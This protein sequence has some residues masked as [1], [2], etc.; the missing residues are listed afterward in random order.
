MDFWSL[1]LNDA[2]SVLIGELLRPKRKS[3]RPEAEGLDQ[4]NFPTATENR[5]VPVPFGTTQVKGPNCTWYGD[6]QAQALTKRVRTGMLS[7][8]TVFLGYRYLVGME[9]GLCISNGVTLKEV[10][11]G[12]TKVFAG[13]VTHGQTFNVYGSWKESDLQ[14]GVD[15]TCEFYSPTSRATATQSAYV[16]GFV[17][18]NPGYQH[19][20]RV[21]WRGPSAG[22]S[23]F[24]GLSPNMRSLSFVVKRLPDVVPLG[25]PA[26]ENTAYGDLNGAANLAYIAL[27]LA[28]NDEWGAGY[29]LPLIDVDSFRQAAPVIFAEGNGGSFL[30]DG[31]CSVESML[32]Q[33]LRQMNGI[34]VE[35][36]T[37]GLLRLRLIRKGQSVAITI[38]DSN[39]GRIESFTRAAGEDA[40]NEV[41]LPFKDRSADFKD[42][43]A[44][45]QDLGGIRQVGQVVSATVQY[46]LVDNRELASTLVVRDLQVG[47]TALA[48][49]ELKVNVPPGTVLLPGDL[50]DVTLSD[51]GVNNMLM[52][53]LKVSLPGGRKPELSLELVQD[54]FA[55]GTALYAASVPALGG[56][57]DPSERPGPASWYMLG[58]FAP[59][60]LTGDDSAEHSLFMAGPPTTGYKGVAGYRVGYWTNVDTA[61]QRTADTVQWDEDAGLVGFAVKGTT[62][63]AYSRT[64]SGSFSIGISAQ[65]A[66]IV[67]RYPGRDIYVMVQGIGTVAEFMRARVALTSPSAATITPL[68]RGLWDTQPWDLPA[69]SLAYLMFGYACDPLPLAFDAN[70]QLTSNIYARTQSYGP[71]GIEDFDAQ[72]KAAADAKLL[73]GTWIGTRRASLPYPPA[74]LRLNGA[75]GQPSSEASAALDTVSKTSLV[76]AWMPRNKRAGGE[77]TYTGGDAAFESGTT[78][79]A[80]IGYT[81]PNG[82]WVQLFQGTVTSGNTLTLT[83]SPVIPTG[84]V[85]EASVS[86]YYTAT[87]QGTY[88]KARWKAA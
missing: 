1:L 55:A 86:C 44:I 5:P 16:G 72:G 43:S 40:T 24:V 78:L 20:S 80:N 52:R 32:E 71:G 51:L 60:A 45:A 15:A 69:G 10:W 22:G 53:V 46:P 66:E 26:S 63:A 62:S 75:V 21:V 58:A 83:P 88:T 34:L 37:T 76:F 84:S 6:Y 41:R 19:L 81:K 82:Q 25:V 54:V 36:P 14:S 59:Y 64:S 11:A 27:E 29:P 56:S 3:D 87:G 73:V 23:G 50:A 68:G 30:W 8:E 2:L 85:I 33:V 47:I 17:A 39:L 70:V 9:L 49:A 35:D 4:F 67:G 18:T 12:D 31:A 57:A 65:D 28:A 48:K 77:S 7:K 74:D 13:N 38:N 79:A 42:R 61:S